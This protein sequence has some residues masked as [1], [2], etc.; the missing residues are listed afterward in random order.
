MKRWDFNLEGIL[1]P[2]C[3]GKK[4]ILEP[5]DLHRSEGMVPCPG[6]YFQGHGYPICGEDGK[7]HFS[8]YDIENQESLMKKYPK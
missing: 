5:R 4:S 6:G 1:C 3:K 8:E 2:I 7:L